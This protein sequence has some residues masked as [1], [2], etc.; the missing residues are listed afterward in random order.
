MF[1]KKYRNAQRVFDV[2]AR[3]VGSVASELD[4]AKNQTVTTADIDSLLGGM[5]SLEIG[6]F[7]SSAPGFSGQIYIFSCKNNK[8]R[9]VLIQSIY[10]NK[11]KCK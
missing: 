9:S 3:Q 4:T 6:L 8:H 10:Y 5:V 2:E 1:N 7:Y 11:T